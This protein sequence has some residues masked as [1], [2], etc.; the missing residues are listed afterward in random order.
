MQ[1]RD[2]ILPAWRTSEAPQTGR[3]AARPRPKPAILLM[4]LALWVSFIAFGLYIAREAVKDPRWAAA[5]FSAGLGDVRAFQDALRP[6]SAGD[7]F[8]A[9]DDPT[10]AGDRRPVTIT[11]ALSAGWAVLEP[12]DRMDTAPDPDRGESFLS[13]Y[14]PTPSW[15]DPEPAIFLPRPVTEI[16]LRSAAPTQNVH[17]NNTSGQRIDA[18]ALLRAPSPLRSPAAG[19]T[20]LII[21]THGT[22]A[23]L[24]CAE[25]PF[26]PEETYRSTDPDFNVIRI[27]AEVARIYRALGLEVIHDTTLYD[28]PSYNGSYTRALAAITEHKRRHPGITVVIDIHRDALITPQGVEYAPVAQL[29]EGR[30]AQIMLVMGTGASGLPHPDWRENLKVGLRLQQA[31]ETAYPDFMRPLWLRRERFNMHASKGSMLV[32]IGASGNT[33]GQALLAA[34]LF[35]EVT[36]PVLKQLMGI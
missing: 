26:L 6:V 30:A 16:T 28:H 10:P 21:H 9:A 19:P 17:I 8:E 13:P 34:R 36:G 14:W 35:A 12:W 32:E 25:F 4:V 3:R 24:P 1:N 29:P 20:I 27:G 15:G 2:A 23:Y 11:G 7:P 31:L 18:G 5:L 33:M 22:E